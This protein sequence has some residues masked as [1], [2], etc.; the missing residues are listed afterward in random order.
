MDNHVGRQFDRLPPHSLEAERALLASLMLSGGDKLIFA[1]VKGIVTEESFYQAD[2]SIIFD[3]ICKLVE[4]GKNVDPV[5]V[6]EA[7]KSRN[8]WEEVGGKDYLA[9]ILNSVPS[10]AHAVHYAE[11]V[12]RKCLLRGMIANANT[13]LRECYSPGADES[14]I[15]LIARHVSKMQM[16]AVTGS[17][18]EVHH[19]EQIL[20]EV[21]DRRTSGEI[22]RLP[23][24]ITSLDSVI[25][26]LRKGGKAIIGAKA[27]MGKSQLIKQFLKNMASNGIKCGLITVEESRY[28]VGENLIANASGIPNN[29][30]AFGNMSQEEWDEVVGAV[31]K[32]AKL[33]IYVVDSARQISRIV[34]AANVLAV[35]YGC[36]VIAVDHLH[37]ID[38]QTDANREREISKISAELKWVWKDLNVCGIEAA[39]LNRSGGRERPTLASL[40]DSGS[41][42]QDGDTI[43]LLHREDYYR[44][45]EA[46]FIADNILEAIIAKNKDGATGVVPVHFDG[47]RQLICD[48]DPSQQECP[49]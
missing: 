27:S 22:F 43:I 7:L 30:I 28:K 23:T 4:Q 41:L 19:L 12:R 17:A 5:I 37:I 8:L 15:D 24:R 20:H 45:T 39:Q 16:M 47:A 31:L 11:I 35:K 3:V 18:D 49:V 9:T 33:P 13:L 40:R 46:D 26:G 14:A 34:A 38:G 42:E 36:E 2:H 10:Y 29:R 25:G 6:M 44:Q 21:L 48:L 32:L 1:E